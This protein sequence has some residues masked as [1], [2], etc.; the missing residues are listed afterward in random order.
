MRCTSELLSLLDDKSTNTH[1]NTSAALKQ[2]TLCKRAT[3][4]FTRRIFRIAKM[5]HTK[6]LQCK[7]TKV[8]NGPS[9]LIRA[10]L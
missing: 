9:N 10:R 5:L 8:K 7:S 4:F 3:K 2:E 6:N 1:R